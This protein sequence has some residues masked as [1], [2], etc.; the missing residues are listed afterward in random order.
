MGSLRI[1][2]KSPK[3]LHPPAKGVRDSNGIIGVMRDYDPTNS[4]SG[5]F[6][7]NIQAAEQSFVTRV[8]NWMFLGLAATGVVAYIVSTNEAFIRVIY[9]N[10]LVFFALAIGLLIMVWNISANIT[11]MSPEA[12]ATSFFI[13]AA[14]NGVLISSIFIV[15][16]A[17]SIF[18]T[19][20]VAAATFGAMALYGFTTK[21]DLTGIG[22]FAF[23]ALIGLII[24]QLVN[25]F[26]Q[27]TGLASILNYAGV[28]IF[29]ALTAY[30][31]QKIKRIGQSSDYHPNLAISGA[32]A[33]YL[34]FINLFLHLLRIMG[35]RR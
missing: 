34:D 19:F 17:S 20:F 35:N 26:L 21:K 7:F 23:M 6:G 11:K 18:S 2:F 3:Y 10:M 16:T 29:V 32:L 27:S 1:N 14:L 4:G 15:Y 30:D 33:L 28:L 12:A 31:V 5:G 13:Y 24:A 22:S 9:G 25:M 8:F